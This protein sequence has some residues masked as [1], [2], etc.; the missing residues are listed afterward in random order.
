MK[1]ITLIYLAIAASFAASCNFL[2]EDPKSFVDRGSYYKTEAQCVTAVNSCYEGLRAVYTTTLFTHLEGVTDIA[3][4]PSFSDVNAI[5]DI[6]PS[7]C[8][9]SKTVWSTAYKSVMY[10]N[11]AIAGIEGSQSIDT[12]VQAQLLAEAKI[13]RA[14]WYY[15]ITSCFGDVPYYLDDIVDQPTMDRIASMGRMDA[16]ATRADLIAQ[17]QGCLDALP[18]IKASDI[19]DKGRAGWAMGQMLIGKMALWNAYMDTSGTT[20][21]FQTAID[22]LE[23]L[24]PVYG[25]LSQYSLKDLWFSE[26]DTPERI[27]AV[28]HTYIQGQLSYAGTLAQNCM[29]SY[30]ASSELYDGLSIPWLGTEAKV[31]TC[32]RP[33]AY[34]YAALQ[35]DNGTDLRVDVNQ[36]RRWEGKAFT[37]GISRPWMGPKFWCPQMKTTNDSNDYPI[38]RYADAL[39]ML[40][41]CYA[42]KEDKDNFEKNLNAVRSRAGLPAYSTGNWDKARQEVRDERA[43]ELFGEFQRKFDLVRWGIWYDVIKE[44]WQ[45]EMDN[46]GYITHAKRC[47]R[48]LP[49]PIEQVKNSGYAL[50]NKEY[51]EYGL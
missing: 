24:V 38:F 6:N 47:H 9:I 29:P 39:L 15:L 18:K 22:A 43:R 32:N 40:A 12:E 11:A 37:N 10:C 17:L 33:T 49:I 21:W 51:N 50:D 25:S 36:G 20:D 5:L 44:Y 13:M 48:Y 4:V 7:Q 2:K 26:K 27:F 42:A 35:P 41:E 34:F 3:M 1:R 23:Q 31:G 16:V 46:F 14:F 28:R 8:N 30:K 19:A 45:P